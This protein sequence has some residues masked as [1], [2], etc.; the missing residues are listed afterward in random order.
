VVRSTR[1]SFEAV[2]AASRDEARQLQDTV[3]AL[4]AEV[5]QFRFEHA[6]AL[7]H[8]R[9]AAHNELRQL[10]E[11]VALLRAEAESVRAR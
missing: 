5:D 6:A 9:Q 3:R 4:R 8:Q 2:R 1:E 7:E 10:H 11:T